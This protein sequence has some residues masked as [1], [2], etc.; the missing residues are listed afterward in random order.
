[1]GRDKFEGARVAWVVNE[2]EVGFIHDDQGRGRHGLHKRGEFIVGDDGAGGIIGI[3]DVGDAGFR[4]A[5]CGH[6]GKVVAMVGGERN[7]DGLEC[8]TR[9]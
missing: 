9:A 4:G 3:A 1:M 8:S 2:I 7:Q 5:G 6:F